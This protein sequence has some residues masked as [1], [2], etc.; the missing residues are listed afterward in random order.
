MTDGQTTAWAV[1]WRS[2]NQ[3]DGRRNYFIGN[4]AHPCRRHLFFTRHEARQY[5]ADHYSYIKKRKDLKRE[6][7]GWQ[8]PI[9]VKVS[10]NIKRVK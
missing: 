3:L 5:I 10:V 2:T 6:P 9:A 8:P 1:L 4:A 7:H